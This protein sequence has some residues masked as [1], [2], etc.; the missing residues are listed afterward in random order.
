MLKNIYDRRA[1]NFWWAMFALDRLQN[2]MGNHQTIYFDGFC[3]FTESQK[4]KKPLLNK[5]L[6]L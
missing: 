3:L 6:E 2:G 1:T 5:G 4:S